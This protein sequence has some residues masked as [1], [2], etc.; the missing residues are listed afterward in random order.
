MVFCKKTCFQESCKIRRKTLLSSLFFNKVFM[1]VI[2]LNLF[3]LTSWDRKSWSK[4]NYTHNCISC[5]DLT[6]KMSHF[7]RKCRLEQ[8]NNISNF[9]RFWSSNFWKIWVKLDFRILIHCSSVFPF[10]TPCKQKTCG[11]CR[12]YCVVYPKDLPLPLILQRK[13]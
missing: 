13:Y 8:F 7:V 4:N 11:F 9:Y 1:E 3:P 2:A 6:K 12:I 5:E 10:H